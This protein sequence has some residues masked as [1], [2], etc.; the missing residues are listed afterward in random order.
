[1]AS[2]SGTGTAT[3]NYALLHNSTTSARSGSI[4]V[5]GQTLAVTQ[6]PPTKPAQPR[7]VRANS[8]NP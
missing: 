5:G 2:T 6:N 3:L 8:R 1:L 4:V 7:G